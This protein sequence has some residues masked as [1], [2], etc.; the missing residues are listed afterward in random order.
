M[1]RLE[2]FVDAAFAFAIT[3][4]VIAAQQIPDDIGSLLGAFR[5]VPTFA[6]SIAALG[7]FWWGHWIWSRHYGL[8]DG[9]ST[10]ISW[11][12]IMTILIYIYPLK[13]I[14]GAMWYLLSHGRLGEA[15][16]LHATEKQARALFCAYGLGFIA[17]TGEIVLLNVRAWWL[18]DPL[19]LNAHE[20]LM[21]RAAITGWSVPMSTGLLSVVLALTLPIQQIDW[22]GWIYF[23]I[24]ITTFLHNWYYANIQRA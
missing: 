6:C 3:M 21:T 18:R 22:A 12:L 8:Q 14:L 13:A 16:P 23:S 1:T 11:A 9:I 19:R 5:N 2:T 10:L 20:S 15:V 4:L 24:P 17:I 7:I